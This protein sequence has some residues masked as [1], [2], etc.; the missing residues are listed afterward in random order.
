VRADAAG[1]KLADAG[2]VRVGVPNADDAS[3]TVAH[4]LACEK[5]CA[6]MGEDAVAVELPPLG[7]DQAVEHLALGAV[8][9]EC[10][11]TG[12][13]GECDGL[14][15]VWMAGTG[16]SASGQG[17]TKSDLG[18]GAQPVKRE[19]AVVLLRCGKE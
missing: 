19:S 15:P 3:A 8:D 11:G 16:M 1:G 14:G 7:R 10:E 6:A 9:H 13:A 5:P 18:G 17:D 4:L 12:P 2:I